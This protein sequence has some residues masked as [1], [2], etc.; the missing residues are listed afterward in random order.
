MTTGQIQR[1]MEAP[2][3]IRP[4]SGRT[5]FLYFFAEVLRLEGRVNDGLDANWEA[6]DFVY[7]NVVRLNKSDLYRTRGEIYE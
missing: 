3:K 6:Q 2:Q 4:E 7:I 1:R 5:L